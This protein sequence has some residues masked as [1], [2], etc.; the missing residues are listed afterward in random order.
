[1]NISPIFFAIF[2]AIAIACS[3]LV[4][5]KKSP[6]S[7]A[8][9]LVLVFFSFA[10]IYGMLDAHLIAALQ[11][12]V[13]AGAIMVLFLFVIMLLN[14][15]LPTFDLGRSHWL[16][17]VFV[18]VACVALFGMFVWVFK[19][20]PISGPIADFTPEKIEAAGGNTR[21]ASELLFSE[22]ILPFELTSVLLLGA[23]VGTVAIAKR[24]QG[25]S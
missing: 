23:I 22:Y 25:R 17:R 4:I 20:S 7:S 15:D 10:A 5:L 6:V 18:G 11:I 1:M 13:Y 19:E 3:L 24:H 16:Q 21:V 12:L 14:A 9:S 8:F 2:A